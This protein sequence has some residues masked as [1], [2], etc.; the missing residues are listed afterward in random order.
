M[1]MS[2]Q[3]ENIN[4]DIKRFITKNQVK[5]LELTCITAD[6]KFMREAE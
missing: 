3:I 4:K 5:I 6:E 2:H 1:R